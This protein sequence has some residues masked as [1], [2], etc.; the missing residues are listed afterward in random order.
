MAQG[1]FISHEHPTTGAAKIVASPTAR[2]PSAWRAWTPATARTCVSGIPMPRV[3]PGE[4]G[5]DVSANGHNVSLGKLKGNRG[6]QNYEIPAD[7][8]PSDYT[9]VSIWCGR[10]DVPFGTA[11][12]AASCAGRALSVTDSQLADARRVSSRLV[13]EAW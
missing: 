13:A 2:T 1:S 8:K 9:S 6:D 5:W 3:K 11:Q 4:E 7:M 10:F 12:L